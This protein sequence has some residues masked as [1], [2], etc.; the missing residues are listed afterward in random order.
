MFLPRASYAFRLDVMTC[1][2]RRAGCRGGVSTTE[3][4][5]V[6]TVAKGGLMYEASVGRQKFGYEAF[7]KKK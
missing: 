5:A 6:F 4:V 3:G 7:E 2:S 1:S